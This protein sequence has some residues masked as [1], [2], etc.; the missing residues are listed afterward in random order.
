MFFTEL[1]SFSLVDDDFSCGVDS[2]QMHASI[3]PQIFTPV[4]KNLGQQRQK[5]TEPCKQLPSLPTS[6]RTSD[7]SQPTSWRPCDGWLTCTF[8]K[9]N[10]LS[11]SLCSLLAKVNMNIQAEGA[12]SS[13]QVC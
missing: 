9:Y 11:C 5:A 6:T 8:F 2:Q 13:W 3:A 12:Q 7:A 10:I 1:E 4:S